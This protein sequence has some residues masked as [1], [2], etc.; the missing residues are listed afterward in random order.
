MHDKEDKN[1]MGWL[2]HVMCD[3]SKEKFESS[4]LL[5]SCDLYP[6]QRTRIHY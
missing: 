3:V 6:P 5:S 1:M 2:L 4:L